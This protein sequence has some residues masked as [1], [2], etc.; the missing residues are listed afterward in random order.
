MIKEIS[1]ENDHDFREF[2]PIDRIHIS[3]SRHLTDRNALNREITTT[4]YCIVLK[5]KHKMRAEQTNVLSPIAKRQLK[6]LKKKLT[7]Y[8]TNVLDLSIQ[9]HKRK[10]ILK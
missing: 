1:I 9:I 2:P 8:F 10:H 5:I 6:T 4:F 7:G 3:L